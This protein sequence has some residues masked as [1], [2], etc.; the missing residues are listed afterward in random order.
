[1]VTVATLSGGKKLEAKLAEIAAAL[2]S[3]SHT[4]RVGFLEKAAYPDGTSVAAVASYNEFGRT[5]A[6][7]NARGEVAGSYY[8]IPR[9][10]FRTMITAKS[11]TWGKSL[12]GVLK[13]N[14]Y[15]VD[16]SL[17]LMG[18]G[19]KGQLQES[20]TKLVNPPLAQSTID[21]KG[22]SKPLIDTSHMLNSVDY[23]VK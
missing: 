17:K 19:I 18:E 10:F 21:R 2:G 7:K 5:V 22:F 15:H 4:L 3:G 12:A 1:V 11:P 9:P 20:I 8:Q 23:D 6:V 16:R 13:A 14:N